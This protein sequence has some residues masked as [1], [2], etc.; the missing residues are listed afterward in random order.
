[1]YKKLDLLGKKF[2]RL[3]VVSEAEPKHTEYGNRRRWLCLCDCGNYTTVDQTNLVSDRSKSCGCYRK[4]LVT[5]SQTKHG[6][7]GEK[8]RTRLYRVWLGMN[9]R[10]RNPKHIS[11]YL[12]GGRGIGVCNEWKNSYEC[13]KAWAENHG[14]DCD[15]KRGV[16]TLDR[17]DVNADY[18]PDNCRWV[19]MKVQ[20]SNRRNVS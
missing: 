6:E 8:H 5:Q 3:T 12:Y 15:A 14:Y 19:D 20:N 9:E 11:Y 17:I 16:C 13:F 18:S 7:G 10:C 1:M 4:E 2:G